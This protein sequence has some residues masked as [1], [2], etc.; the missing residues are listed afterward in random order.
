VSEFSTTLPS[1][2][3]MGPR[4]TAVRIERKKDKITQEYLKMVVVSLPTTEEGSKSNRTAKREGSWSPAL[5]R[6]TC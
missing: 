6:K 2:L 1:S 3:F 5:R 4:R